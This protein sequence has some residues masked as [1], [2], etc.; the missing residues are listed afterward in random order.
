MAISV[1]ISLW[2]QFQSEKAAMPRL[3]HPA[4]QISVCYLKKR[5]SRQREWGIRVNKKINYQIRQ[6]K[7]TDFPKKTPK[8][9]PA[10]CEIL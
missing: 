2:P 6:R 7:L 3:Y 5:E 8:K 10:F 9:S 4:T 1:R